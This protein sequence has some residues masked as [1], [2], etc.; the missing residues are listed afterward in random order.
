MPGRTCGSQSRLVRKS[1]TRI[2]SQK[3]AIRGDEIRKALIKS[4]L[5]ISA[6]KRVLVYR[7]GSLGDTVVALPCFH[8]IA[9]IFPNSERRLLTN[10]PVSTKAP[11]AAS[12]LGESGLIHSYMSYPVGMRNFDALR[13]LSAYIRE[14]KPDL[15]V[16]LAAPRGI[17]NTLRD[18]CFFRANGVKRIVGLAWRRYRRTTQ[19][20]VY[21]S[22]VDRLAKSISAIGDA[23]PDDPANWDLRLSS[24]E[25][26]RAIELLREWP[27][28][29]SFVACSVGTKVEVNDW[30]VRNWQSLLAK[31]GNRNP[32]LG[33]L[34]FG[35][36]EEKDL[37]S[38]AAAEWRGPLLN[39]CGVTSPREM[40]A[41]LGSARLFVG[42][43]S[44]PMHLAAAVGTRCVAVFSARN[45]PQVWF[46]Y[47]HGHRVIYHH[48]PC[49]GCE[50]EL[51]VKFKKKCI[52]SVS[53]DE[54]LGIVSE[55]L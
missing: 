9:R 49:A 31:L 37:S 13:R 53:V 18:A 12:I 14:W 15:L 4:I 6:A 26:V 16:Y 38:K 8:L 52:T 24:A 43:D 42:H 35:V 44:G 50:L 47:G 19:D 21:E 41:L 1:A 30:G 28:G 36:T 54:V 33:L 5:R 3:L 51:C 7:L 22:E 29:N 40:A 34:L 23:R 55:A 46:P 27:G 39:L 45:L 25:R 10:I 32:E 20:G 2:F 48:V 17:G 11:G